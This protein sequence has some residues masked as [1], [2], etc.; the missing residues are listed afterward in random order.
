MGPGHPWPKLSFASLQMENGL[1]GLEEKAEHSLLA[2]G[3]ERARLQ[4]QCHK[5]QRELLLQQR[6]QALAG[7][8][9]A[10]VG[11]GGSTW[12][13]PALLPQPPEC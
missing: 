11:A 9:D 13:E 1:A 7:T 3:Q 2:M 10:Q 6:R 4:Q 5:L 12:P 8:L